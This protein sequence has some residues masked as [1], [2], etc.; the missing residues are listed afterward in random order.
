MTLSN[1][2]DIN[3]A[4]LEFLGDKFKGK[5]TWQAES[6]LE[7]TRTHMFIAHT[8]GITDPDPEE[9]LNTYPEKERNNKKSPVF[10]RFQFLFKNL[11]IWAFKTKDERDQ[12][13][14]K[15]QAVAIE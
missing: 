13:C 7:S 9:F 15:N 3:D 5:E 6:L 12:F 1:Q 11:T 8:H 2:R 4:I 10:L 14:E